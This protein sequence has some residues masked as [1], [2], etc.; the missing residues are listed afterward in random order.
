[1]GG[2]KGRYTALSTSYNYSEYMYINSEMMATLANRSTTN[3]R[4]N[5]LARLGLVLDF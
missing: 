2:F 4:N 5:M 3:K 1:M